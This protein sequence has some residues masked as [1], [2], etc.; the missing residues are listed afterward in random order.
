[1]PDISPLR[2]LR[3]HRTHDEERKA[4]RELIVDMVV[5]P[6]RCCARPALR[7]AGR[8]KLAITVSQASSSDGHGG[9]SRPFTQRSNSDSGDAAPDCYRCIQDDS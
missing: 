4:V 7:Q 5:V 8:A 6:E 3:K 9:Y 2:L 1:M